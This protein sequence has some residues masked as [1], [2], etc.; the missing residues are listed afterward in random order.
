[1]GYSAVLTSYAFT[2]EMRNTIK[3][4]TREEQK[5]YF[6]INT[7]FENPILT[8]YNHTFGDGINTTVTIQKQG[9]INYNGVLMGYNYLIV[10][11]DKEEAT[12]KYYYYYIKGINYTASGQVVLTLKLDILQTY[13]MDVTFTPCLIKRA[14]LDR[15][16]LDGNTA[17]FN[18]KADSLL[19]EPETD[20]LHPKRLVERKKL[21]L[22]RADGKLTEL[23][24]F[25]NDNVA[26]WVYVYLSKGSYN[27]KTF[28]G[29]NQNIKLFTIE[30]NTENGSIDGS[31]AVLCYPVMKT[32]TASVRVG[33]NGSST[34]PITISSTGFKAFIENNED[35]TDKIYNQKISPLPPLI[36]A[37]ELDGVTFTIENGV[38]TIYGLTSPYGV[39]AG[40]IYAYRTHGNLTSGLIQVGSQKM[41]EN[42]EFLISTNGVEFD[43]LQKSFTIDEI[44]ADSNNPKYNPKL[45][46]LAYITLSVGVG[47]GDSYEYDPQQLGLQPYSFSYAEPLTAEISK[48]YISYN[49]KDANE[50]YTKQ[51]TT[52]YN[53]YI[54]SN[55]ISIPYNNSQY[56]SFISANK[57]FWLQKGIDRT[58]TLVNGVVGGVMGGASAGGVGAVVGGVQGAFSSTL[59]VGLDM[60]K[61]KLQVD[62]M[63][64]SKQELKNAQGNAIFNIEIQDIG[65][66]VALYK[67]LDFEINKANDQMVLYGYTYNRVDNIKNHDSTRIVHNYIVAIVD[68]INCPYPISANIVNEFKRL[69]LMGVR[70]WVNGD[71]IANITASNY[72][73]SLN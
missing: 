16:I 32:K 17:T 15:F 10:R 19:F 25:F 64:A 37:D 68:Y 24:K 4:N 6:N 40:N 45:Q 44:K 20:T 38:A 13:Y 73:R 55:D 50:I 51:T 14:M 30:H 1:M 18:Y 11:D 41:R 58:E 7:L 2:E 69:F 22:Q 36:N 67:A 70:F 60:V 27:F 52:N 23:Y 59:A 66:T 57:N 8:N 33:V 63:R 46:S 72:E 34:T 9:I 56:A 35:A 61:T 65:V 3:F 29:Q 31:T 54:G 12:I 28:D 21:T 39:F 26:F 62:N 71:N 53:G 47:T 5:G 48:Y 49:P 42:E 43:E